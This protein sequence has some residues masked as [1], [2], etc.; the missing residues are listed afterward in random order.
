MTHWIALVAHPD[1]E[2][3]FLGGLL[4]RLAS[5]SARLTVVCATAGDAGR[6][7][8]GQGLQGPTLARTRLAELHASLQRL[9][10][11]TPP[12]C[13]HLPD[14]QL[15][16]VPDTTWTDHFAGLPRG[17]PRTWLTLDLDGAY[18]HRDHTTLT[19]ALLRFGLHPGDHVWARTHA[20]DSP[21]THVHQRLLAARPALIDAQAPPP[22]AGWAHRTWGVDLE[23]HRAARLHALQAHRTQVH[24]EH[25]ERFLHPDLLPWLTTQEGEWYRPLRPA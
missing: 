16:A 19:Q 14:S 6:D 22:G 3:L 15:H 11:P 20:P 24:P 7:A 5:Q 8:T 12:V 18:G 23:P 4:H 9:T 21:L 13:W 25:P 10:I 1:D 17:E 2:A